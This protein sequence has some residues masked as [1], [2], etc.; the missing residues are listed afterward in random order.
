MNDDG[1]RKK[2]QKA[3]RAGMLNQCPKVSLQHTSLPAPTGW[4]FVFSVVAFD[5]RNYL[6]SELDKNCGE[7]SFLGGSVFSTGESPTLREED[8][9]L[10]GVE[11]RDC[12]LTYSCNSLL[13]DAPSS[14]ELGAEYEFVCCRA[15]EEHPMRAR[16][17]PSFI[18]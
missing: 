8:D 11:V 13:N 5:T 17:S 1:G 14:R 3:S 9:K 2:K 18:R 12:I 4:L 15:R 16:M 10:T 6:A 7:M